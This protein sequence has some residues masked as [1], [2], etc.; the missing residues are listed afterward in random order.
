MNEEKLKE[1]LP[2]AFSLYKAPFKYD[3][4]G[5][6]IFDSEENLVAD[7][8][9]WGRIEKLGNGIE[10][11]DAIGELMAEALNDKWK[12]LQDNKERREKE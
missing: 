5:Q 8:R 11:Q 9:G 7:I 10:L 12:E 6:M 2:R 3:F 4:M 1:L